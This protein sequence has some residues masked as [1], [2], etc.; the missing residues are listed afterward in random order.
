MDDK[1]LRKQLYAENKVRNSSKD[2]IERGVL[3]EEQ[4]E[5]L[6]AICKLRHDAHSTDPLDILAFGTSNSEKFLNTIDEINEM[7][8][9]NN[10]PNIKWNI[11]LDTVPT[12]I[13]Y[14]ELLD[15]EEREEYEDRGRKEGLSGYEQWLKEEEIIEDVVKKK[16]QLNSDI[17]KWLNMVDKKYGT[18]YSPTGFARVNDSYSRIPKLGYKMPTQSQLSRGFRR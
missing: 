2:A 1:Y 12:E 14:Y 8:S 17:E 13:D 9:A 11:D 15:D 10:L 16:E 6:E 3:T 7:V 4:T 5:A 18:N